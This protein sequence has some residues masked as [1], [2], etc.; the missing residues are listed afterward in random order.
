MDARGV[1][2]LAMKIFAG[3]VLLII[4]LGIGYAVYG[5]AGGFATSLKCNL[6]LSE[7]SKSISRGGSS[8]LTVTV[9]Y[10]MGTKENAT[11]Q[12]TGAPQGVNISFYPPRGEPT[13]YSTLSISADNTSPLGTYTLTISAIGS[14]GQAGSASLTLTIT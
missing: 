6:S 12:A 5:W 13:F 9:E 8:T 10:L 4:G 1:E 11:L 14:K 7:P 2:P 3:I